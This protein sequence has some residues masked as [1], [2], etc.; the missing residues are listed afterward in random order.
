M[1]VTRILPKTPN[2]ASICFHLGCFTCFV[3]MNN[4]RE[5]SPWD[6][7]KLCV[8][9]DTSEL[10]VPLLSDWAYSNYLN[11]GSCIVKVF[12]CFKVANTQK[13][14]KIGQNKFY[15]KVMFSH[16][17]LPFHLATSYR[18]IACFCRI[19]TCRKQ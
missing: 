11:I 12:L 4:L 10:L 2:S 3:A 14:K 8:K 1:F 17:F 6:W 7:N 5:T 18:S 13:K 19:L 16:T 15:W 9:L